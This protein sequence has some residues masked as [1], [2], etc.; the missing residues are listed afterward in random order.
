MNETLRLIKSRRSVKKYKDTPVSKADIEKIVEAGT[1][2]A[3]GLN[4]QSPIILAVTNKEVIKKIWKIAVFFIPTAMYLASE[5]CWKY[6]KER[7]PTL[8]FIFLWGVS[9]A[10]LFAWL[11]SR[12]FKA[13][14]KKTGKILLFGLLLI[15]IN[16]FI[17]LSILPGYYLFHA[18]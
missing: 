6:T 7:I 15:G 12:V 9:I 10:G 2:A 11:T 18:K 8:I 13:K 5:L 1:W 17:L 4:R 3:T 14:Y 16:L